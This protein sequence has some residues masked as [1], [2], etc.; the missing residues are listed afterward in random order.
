MRDECCCNQ[1]N[2]TS[3]ATSRSMANTGSGSRVNSQ[4]KVTKN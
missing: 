4:H 1:R 3:A 2:A